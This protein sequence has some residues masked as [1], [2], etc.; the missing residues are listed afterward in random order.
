MRKQYDFSKARKNPYTVHLKQSVTIRLGK[1]VV[2]YFKA[3]AD[4]TGIPYQRLINLYLQECA[5]S[6]KRLDLAWK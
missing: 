4:D 3:L 2:A 1:D 5:T 6:K